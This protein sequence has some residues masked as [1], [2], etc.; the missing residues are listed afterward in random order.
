VSEKDKVD[1]P[2][3]AIPASNALVVY[4]PPGRPLKIHKDLVDEIC[5]RVARGERIKDICALDHMPSIDT[6]YKWAQ[7]FPEFSESLS[8]ARAT[9]AD[10]LAEELFE[11][12]DDG[13]NDWME[14]FNKNGESMG[15][16]LNGEAVQRSRLRFEM[17]KFLMGKYNPEKY[18][19]SVKIGGD[20]KNP[21]QVVDPL[22]RL[23][24]QIASSP[25]TTCLPPQ[26][27]QKQS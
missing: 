3:E 1:R 11:I 27:Q 2:F 8:R 12:A 14:K 19:E 4:R 25:E 24:T 6:F 26:L 20:K 18:G 15:W 5:E 17:R 10:H 13:S 16:F 9:Q 7:R 21:L 22:S 23:L